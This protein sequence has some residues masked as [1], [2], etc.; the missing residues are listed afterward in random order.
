MYFQQNFER[1]FGTFPLKGDKL[2]RALETALEI[3]YRAIDTAQFYDNEQDIAETISHC[4]IPRDELFLTSKVP[5]DKFSAKHFRPSVEQSLEKLRVNELDVLLLHWPP[6]DGHIDTALELLLEVQQAGL[7]RHIGVSNFTAAM[8]RR[9]KT[10][11]DSPIVTNQVEFHPLLNQDALLMAS[12]ETDIPLASYCSVARG[13]VFDIPLLKKLA[14]DYGVTI[15]QIVLRWILQK[16][17]S[18]NAMSTNRENIRTN[19][20]VLSFTLSA[21]DMSRIDALTHQNYRIVD[22]ELV[23]WAPV[24]D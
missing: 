9:C 19:F 5:V 1:G 15:G 20:D 16:G 10:L 18:V 2:C 12:T 7:C 17:V 14:A 21:V 22:K 24:W 8:L 3:G 4:D 6:A 13:K 23:P 11:T